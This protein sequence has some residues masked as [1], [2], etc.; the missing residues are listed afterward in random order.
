MEGGGAK[1]V[2]LT[3]GVLLLLPVIL[4]AT[5][6][7][8]WPGLLI[9]AYNWFWRRR[10]GL[11]VK[12]SDVGAFRFCYSTRGTPGGA[13]SL[14]LLHGFSANK[15]MWLPVVKF[16]PPHLH[17]VCLDLPGHDGTSRTQT[18][19][20]SIQG[21]VSR[22]HQFVH[23]VG[24]RHFHLVGTSM[25]GNLAGV[26]AARFPEDLC[27]VSLVC[28]AGLEP[29]ED[30]AFVKRLRE[31]EVQK[32][33][34]QDLSQE[35]I[36]LIPNTVAQLQEMLDL[37][38]YKPLNLPKQM[39]KGLL[40]NRLPHNPFYR[41]LFESISAEDSRHSL[42]ENLQHITVPVQ[43]VW[44]QQDQ[45]LHVSG[46]S[47]IAAALPHSQVALL[48]DCGHSVALERPRKLAS[49]LCSFLSAQEVTNGDVKKK[50]C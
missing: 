28:P 24:L 14:L 41:H 16:L 35:S 7:M 31:L 30:T 10:L 50:N 47:V 9:K 29:P 33:Q 18:E 40:Q 20:Y 39:M 42:Q 19:D 2:M 25:G 17:V 5:S 21:Q 32:Q 6:F 44:G 23:S 26:Y 15:D 46:A 45:V 3:G 13:P 4:F 22:I 27:S 1:A 38:C 11:S 8:F 34:N 37:C 49:L 12:V 43:V 48:D 36:A